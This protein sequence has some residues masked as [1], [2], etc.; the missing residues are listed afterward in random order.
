MKNILIV[1]FLK[2]S[3]TLKPKHNGFHS[4]VFMLHVIPDIYLS[5]YISLKWNMW[6]VSKHL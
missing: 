5:K 2:E 3:K 6:R 4:Y 1:A